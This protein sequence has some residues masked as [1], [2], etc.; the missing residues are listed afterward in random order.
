MSIYTFAT[1]RIALIVFASLESIHTLFSEGDESDEM[2][3]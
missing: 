3:G 1:G 2:F